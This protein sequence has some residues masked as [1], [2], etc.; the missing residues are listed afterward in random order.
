[1]PTIPMWT[2]YIHKKPITFKSY[3]NI[4]KRNFNFPLKNTVTFA[5]NGKEMRVS[6]VEPGSTLIEFLR[7]KEIRLTGTKLVCGEGGCGACTVQLS[8]WDKHKK[9]IIHKS[10]N[11][12]L[13]PF[14]S[15]D[16]HHVIT[17][18]GIGNT[19]CLHPIQVLSFFS[20]YLNK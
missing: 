4:S 20:S 1:V 15:I 13:V 5:L 3:S 11:S 10:V 2:A 16:G 17:V 7:S 8:R 6:G 19:H 9:A 12:C 18:E 14:H